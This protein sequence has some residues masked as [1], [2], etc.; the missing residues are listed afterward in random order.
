MQSVQVFYH[1]MTVLPVLQKGQSV[2]Y[3]LQNAKQYDI[4]AIIACYAE[5][6]IGHT[7]DILVANEKDLAKM[8][9]DN[10]KYDRLLLNEE[11]IVA[12][13]NDAKKLAMHKFETYKILEERAGANGINI[14]KVRVP[15][16]VIGM[17][18]ESRP[19]V[20][21]DAISLCLK[22]RNVCVLKGSGD[23]HN[24]NTALMKIAHNILNDANMP[25]E[26]ATLLEPTHDAALQLITAR[27]IVDLC[28]PRGS[29][30]LIDFVIENATVPF[31]ETGAGVVHI[32]IDEDFDLE[33][34]KQVIFNSK[35]RRPSV[36]NSLDCIVIAE[37]SLPY[38]GKIL[39]GLL[40]I[41]TEILCDSASF[42]AMCHLNSGQVRMACS[43]D[44]GYEFL[45]LKLAIKVVKDVNDAVDFI[46][47]KSSKHTECIVT[48]NMQHATK[49]LREIDAS[50]VLH[51]TSTGFT[52]GGCF[53]MISEIGISTQK[54]HARGP[55][56]L[57]ELLT[58]KWIVR[59]NGEIRK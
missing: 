21:V 51:N 33:I 29:R 19:N 24:T 12:I 1:K 35:A 32:Y 13:A 39:A 14:Q 9:K 36:C 46:N 57:D 28:I 30:T 41:G 17:I 15:L 43:K 56:S 42:E 20:T 54:L 34:A 59:S 45:S 23:A 48:N 55:F 38:I 2:K 31:I 58:Y 44:Y 37:K 7:K 50:T 3:S 25:V 52:D 8:A 5:G 18:Y 40:A 26:V 27:G 49:F 53:G 22:S 10:P 4:D 11:R 47:E 16:G 6:L